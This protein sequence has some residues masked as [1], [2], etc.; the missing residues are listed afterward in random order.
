LRVLL[1]PPHAAPAAHHILLATQ[2]AA[3]G[4]VAAAHVHISDGC[5]VAQ[6]DVGQLNEVGT[7]MTCKHVQMAHHA[8]PQHITRLL[9]ST[10]LLLAMLLQHACI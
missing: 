3:L 6:E 5:T 1:L 8:A 9:P 10:K 4:S 7:A 2:L